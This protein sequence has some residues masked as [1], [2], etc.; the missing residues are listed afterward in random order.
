MQLARGEVDA[1]IL[2]LE[3]AQDT[4]RFA[5]PE[6]EWDGVD[7]EIGTLLADAREQRTALARQ[8]SVASQ[9]E[10]RD[11]LRRREEAEREL[12]RQRVNNLMDEAI[13]AFRAQRYDDA[14]ELTEDVLKLEP[15]N[16]RAQDLRD[17][18]ERA[19]REKVQENYLRNKR[20]QYLRW[21][22][23]MD[24]LRTPNTDIITLPDEEYWRDITERRGKRRGLD[25]DARRVRPRSSSC[26]RRWRIDDDPGP[27]DQRGGEPDGG[28]RRP[29]AITGLPM[30]VDP[31][32]EAAA[33]DEGVVFDLDLSN[34]LTVEKALNLIDRHGRGGGHLDHPPR[35][36][37]RSRPRRRRAASPSSS[38]T[39]CRTS[40]SA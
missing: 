3:M 30:V 32:A 31:A 40:S 18:A 39:T 33:I 12:R 1:A 24:D 20:E 37:A 36:R 26:A 29:R 19:K 2:E 21:Q 17:T 13:E 35:R 25:L 27:A 14:I 4:V 28:D 9:R 16:E 15:R 22:E 11:E 23:D 5:P 7:S 8:E 38:T 10:T 6:V 34:P